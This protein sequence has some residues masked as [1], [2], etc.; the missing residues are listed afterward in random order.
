MSKVKSK[1]RNVNTSLLIRIIIIEPALSNITRRIT[2]VQHQ[3]NWALPSPW[4]NKTQQ[5]QAKKVN[6]LTFSTSCRG[7]PNKRQTEKDHMR[8]GNQIQRNIPIFTARTLCSDD[9]EKPSKFILWLKI[10]GEGMKDRSQATWFYGS[11]MTT[12]SNNRSI[13]SRKSTKTRWR[14]VN[15]LLWCP[16]PYLG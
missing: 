11:R 6:S 2:V 5:T 13:R 9:R 4:R 10:N 14:W 16:R 15:P 8:I 12:N 7:R 3:P 1:V